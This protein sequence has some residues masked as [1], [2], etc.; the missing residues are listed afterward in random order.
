MQ[1]KLVYRIFIGQTFDIKWRAGRD[2]SGFLPSP[3]GSPGKQAIKIVPDD[4]FEPFKSR[5]DQSVNHMPT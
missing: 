1:K 5:L 3:F 2:Y 4:F